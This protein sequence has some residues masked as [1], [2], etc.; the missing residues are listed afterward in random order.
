MNEVKRCAI[1]SDDWDYVESPSGGF[2]DHD[3]YAALEAECERLRQQVATLQSDANSW[4]SGY[5][6]GRED[7][8]KAAEGWKA[9]HARDSA[10]LRRLCSERDEQWRIRRDVEADRDTANAI[11]AELRAE[12]DALHAEAEALRAALLGI[13]SVNPAERGIEWAKSYASDGLNGAGS[14]L[15][16]RWLDT[17]KEAE[18]LRAEN[19]RL[20]IARASLPVGVPDGWALV[21]HEAIEYLADQWPGAYRTFYAIAVDSAPSAQQSAPERGDGFS[22]L[23]TRQ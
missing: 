22:E 5:D 16:A 2:V 6:K 4:Q 21:R 20:S 13:A 18:A 14:E 1:I 19:A 3:D 23:P 8:A 7:G 12:R 15:Y 9:Q 17:F 11:S 10:E